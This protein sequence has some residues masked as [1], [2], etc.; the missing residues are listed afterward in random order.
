MEPGDWLINLH[1]VTGRVDLS[2]LITETSADATTGGGR[3]TAQI[4][5]SHDGP[6]LAAC[7]LRGNSI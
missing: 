6:E 5:S 4:A 2:I 7:Y 3:F 1:E